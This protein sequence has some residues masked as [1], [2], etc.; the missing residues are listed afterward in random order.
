ME[1]DVLRI[2]EILKFWFGS[3][4][5]SAF[6][7]RKALWFGGDP[8]FDDAVR[9]EL[10]ADHEQAA[11]G[12]RDHWQDTP[13]GTLALI[14][15]LD[16]VPRN[17]FRSSPRAYAT[18]AQALD[19]AERGLACGF[20]RQLPPAQRLFLVLPFMH[21]ERLDHQHRALAVAR[22]CHAE[23]PEMADAVES[24]LQHL[25]IIERFGRFPHRNAVLGRPT[26]A[27]EAVFLQERGSSF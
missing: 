5:T 20:N 6:A 16:Q 18:D 1:H 19:T 26:T 24:A 23:D 13:R 3:G 11:A 2:D 25:A 17:I 12:R 22:Q 15:L 4:Q 27:E 7:V 9:R 14:L 8:E 21:S 10:A